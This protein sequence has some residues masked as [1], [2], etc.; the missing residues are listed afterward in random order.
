MEEEVSMKSRYSA[1][2]A[3]VAFL[4]ASAVPL[5]AHHSVAAEFDREKT[6]TVVGT[7][8]RVDW[9][10]P[11][12]A[13]WVDVKDLEEAGKVSRVGCQGNPPNA[14]SRAGLVKAD[15]KVGQT[16]TLTCLAAKS[17]RKTWGFLKTI[18]YQDGSALIFRDPDEDGN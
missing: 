6:F 13:T 9:V 10:N 17:G 1:L 3:L 7:L 8:A 15:W 14:Y 12:T 16:V 11:H 5:I 4:I 18:K 2:L